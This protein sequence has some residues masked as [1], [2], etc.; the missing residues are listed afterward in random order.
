ML[1]FELDAFNS[2]G[3]TYH[4]KNGFDKNKLIRCNNKNKKLQLTVGAF[5][6][7][8][9]R[10]AHHLTVQVRY[11]GWQLPTISQEQGC[12]SRGGI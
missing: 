2:T 1:H 3:I 10:M 9:P 6:A 4:K 7:C 5:Y 11:G 8:A 12:P